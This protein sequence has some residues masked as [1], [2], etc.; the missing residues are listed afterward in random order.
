[1]AGKA[2][3]HRRVKKAV[4]AYCDAEGYDLEVFDMAGGRKGSNHGRVIVWTGTHRVQVGVAGSSKGGIETT[5]RMVVSHLKNKIIRLEAG[6]DPRS[7]N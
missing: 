2:K 3:L 5:C 4:Q 1:M 7:G 6:L